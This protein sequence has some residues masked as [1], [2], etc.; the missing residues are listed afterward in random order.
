MKTSARNQLNGK[1]VEVKKGAVN[2]EVVL[3]IAGG[4]KVTAVVTNEGADEL[5]LKVGDAATAIVKAS[6]IILATEAPK[7]ISARNC[8]EG[9]VV[10]LKDGAVNA[11]VVLEV[12]GGAK[13]TAIVTE[14]AIADMG[15]K[16]GGKAYA[17]IK[18]SSVILSA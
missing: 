16:V 12:A 18:A 13:I 5:S 3:E 11:E 9:K 8:L 6:W 7:K 10:V 2:S 1:V 15:L 4:A 14:D 17:I